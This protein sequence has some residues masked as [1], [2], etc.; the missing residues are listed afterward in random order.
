MIDK[1]VIANMMRCKNKQSFFALHQIQKKILDFNP[2]IDVE[3]HILWDSNPDKFENQDDPYY[4][5]LID[6]HIKNLHSYDRVFFKEYSK[7]MYGIENVDRFDGWP[8]IYHILMAHYL[9][10]VK[11][12][13]YYLIYD[14]DILINYDFEDITKLCLNKTPVLI[15][16]PMNINCDK[17]F[18][19]N[20][21]QLYGR[22]FYD[23]YVLRNPNQYGFNAGFQGIDLSMY[24]D[25]LSVDRFKELIGMFD[26]RAPF[27]NDGNEIWGTE[28]FVLD[29]QQQSFFSLMNVVFGKEGVHILNPSEYFVIPNWGTHPIYGELNSEDGFD[30]WSVSL[31]SKITHFIGHTQGKGKPVVLLKLVDEYLN[32]NGFLK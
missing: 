6:T 32:L 1:I 5:Q 19:N 26:I 3:F 24:D 12:Y 14:D 11:L 13:D 25:F 8:A 10:R 20:L 4:S 30:G 22:E 17:V 2:N 23:R 31:K 9:R 29:T 16:E 7:G 21:I 15:C 27:D 28:R 18:I